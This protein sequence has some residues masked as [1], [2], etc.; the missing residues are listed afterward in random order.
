MIVRL[1]HQHNPDLPSGK[2]GPSDAPNLIL[3]SARHYPAHTKV[4]KQRGHDTP[5]SDTS[6]DFK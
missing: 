6:V 2:R 1:D 3:S 4:K 5:L